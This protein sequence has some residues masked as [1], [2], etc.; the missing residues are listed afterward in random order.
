M[1]YLFQTFTVGE[2]LA[3]AK[4]N[5]VEVNIR[6]HVHGVAGVSALAATTMSGKLS[7]TG[8]G[9][10][11]EAT[12]ATTGNAYFSLQNTTG[13]LY[14]GVESNAGASL[15]AGGTANASVIGSPGA[16]ALEFGAN[17][18]I[19][20]TIDPSGRI[21]LGTTAAAA[22][23]YG[24]PGDVT[25]GAG[26]LARFKNTA[27]AWAQYSSLGTPAIQDSVNVSSLTDNGAGDVT[28]N[29][30]NATTDAKGAAVVSTGDGIDLV[31]VNTLAA[32]SV[33]ITT[34]LSGAPTDAS[35]VTMAL[36]AA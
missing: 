20:Q 5:Q 13:K 10:Q 22:T 19:Y 17:G 35:F 4:L 26:N 14:L 31:H 11:I 2:V 18:T 28:V 7:L 12:G 21:F 9:L 16:T 6:D 1:S 29:L 23:G 25:A 24:N 36:F 30:T 33:R 15:F 32:G 34:A 8:G 27:K 3:A